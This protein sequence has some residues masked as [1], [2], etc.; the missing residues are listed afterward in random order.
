MSIVVIF[1]K[2]SIGAVNLNLYFVL[3]VVKLKIEFFNSNLILIFINDLK[4]L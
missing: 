2:K 3:K 4:S 1:S